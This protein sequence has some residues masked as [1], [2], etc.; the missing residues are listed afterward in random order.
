[1]IDQ[2]AEDF[3]NDQIASWQ[4]R[5]QFDQVAKDFKKSSGPEL[6]IPEKVRASC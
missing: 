3:K 6:R 4:F 5:K 1:M 2:V